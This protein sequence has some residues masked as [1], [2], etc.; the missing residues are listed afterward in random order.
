V[1]RLLTLEH[2]GLGVTLGYLV[3]SLIGLL[4]NMLVLIRFRVNYIAYAEPADF[5]LA[6]VRDRLVVLVCVAPFPLYSILIRSRERQ[7]KVAPRFAA[8]WRTRYPKLSSPAAAR[9]G[10]LIA[11]MLWT[12]AFSLNTRRARQTAYGRG[13]D[14]N[15]GQLD[16]VRC[17]EQSVA[18]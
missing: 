2:A 4:H 1:R 5:L 6:A 3:L 15:R 16:V 17:A 11:T 13:S 10:A 8:W 18:V 14:A 9:Q 7:E 12:I